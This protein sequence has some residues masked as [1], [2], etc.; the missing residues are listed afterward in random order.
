MTGVVA[1]QRSQNFNPLPALSFQAAVASNLDKDSYSQSCG[2]I[3][4]L[5]PRWMSWSEKM[6]F[7]QLIY[8]INADMP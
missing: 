2:E 6:R 7:Y 5:G 1:Y 4:F 3:S 8:P